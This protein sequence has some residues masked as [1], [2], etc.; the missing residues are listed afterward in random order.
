LLRILYNQCFVD[1]DDTSLDITHNTHDNILLL[2]FTKIRMALQRRYMDV[3]AIYDVYTSY[4]ILTSMSNDTDQGRVC[5]KL[6]NHKRAVFSLVGLGSCT[7]V[8]DV[9]R[10]VNSWPKYSEGRSKFTVAAWHMRATRKRVLLLLLY[11]YVRYRYYRHK[12]YKR[13]ICFSFLFYC[14]VY[15]I[16]NLINYLNEYRRT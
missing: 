5:T 14:T 8:E 12:L 11:V 9:R 1:L 13:G 4:T 10:G 15:S 2:L 3:V 6:R 7:T 16:W